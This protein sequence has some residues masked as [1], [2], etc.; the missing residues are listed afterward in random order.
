MNYKNIPFWEIKKFN[1]LVE[2]P[3]GSHD[4]F[5]Y[6]WETE[7]FDLDFVMKGGWKWPFNYGEILGT[8][9]GGG[10]RLDAM[11]LSSHP[12]SK[13]DVVKCKIIGMMDLSDR[14]EVDNKLFVIPVN[15]P[16]VKK[17]KNITNI[18]D[19]QR[20]VFYEFYMELAKQKEKV[21]EIKGFLGKK[22]LSKK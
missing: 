11:V 12:I 14:R 10:D 20:K 17:Y 2:I 3:E 18:S 9:G 16:L 15:D 19:K 5:K 6:N 21:M 8:L 7:K 1:V 13:G 22:K 4:K